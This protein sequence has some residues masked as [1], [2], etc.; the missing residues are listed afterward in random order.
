[1]GDFI[2]FSFVFAKIEKSALQFI[3]KCR[4][5]RVDKTIYLKIKTKFK[6]IDYLIL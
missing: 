6:N 4:G 1:M 2:L 5:L 3:W